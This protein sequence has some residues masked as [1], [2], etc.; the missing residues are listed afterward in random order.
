MKKAQY[1]TTLG[2]VRREFGTDKLV[3]GQAAVP[4]HYRSPGFNL[5]LCAQREPRSQYDRVQ[6]VAIKTDITGHGAVIE[7]TREGR[8]KVNFTSGSAL[9]KATLRNFNYYLYREWLRQCVTVPTLRIV[10]MGKNLAV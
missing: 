9:E 6:K 8:N 2:C 10:R 7:R 1:F 3:I 5:D 4:H